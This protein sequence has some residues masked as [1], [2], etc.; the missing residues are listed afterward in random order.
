MA[1]SPSKYPGMPIRTEA[2]FLGQKVVVTL[3][4]V[5]QTDLTDTDFSIPPDYKE[6]NPH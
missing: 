1:I 4:S 3:E 6:L 5:Q 2:K